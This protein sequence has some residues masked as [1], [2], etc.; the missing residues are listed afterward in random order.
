MA[1]FSV[2]PPPM[3]VYDVP[4]LFFPLMAVYDVLP[5][6]MGVYDRPTSREWSDVVN[7]FAKR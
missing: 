4:L 3:G 1:V 7:T 5:P 6:L 2:F